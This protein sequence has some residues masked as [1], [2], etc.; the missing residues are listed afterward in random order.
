MVLQYYF[1]LLSAPF[2]RGARCF[3]SRSDWGHNFKRFQPTGQGLV[4][5]RGPK[6]TGDPKSMQP[7]WLFLLVSSSPVIFTRSLRP[8]TLRR[9]PWLRP[10]RI[11]IPS[12]GLSLLRRPARPT[13]DYDEWPS[14]LVRSHMP[15]GRLARGWLGALQIECQSPCHSLH[16]CRSRL[17]RSWVVAWRAVV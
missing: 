15:D 7:S 16:G 11:Q 12:I 2:R 17:F 10:A 8:A 14:A 6:W 9:T 3:R 5:D 13:T 1:C 4:I